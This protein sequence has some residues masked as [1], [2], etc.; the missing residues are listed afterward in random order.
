MPAQLIS[1]MSDFLIRNANPSIVF[2]IKHD[3][4]GRI[5]DGER[6]ELQDRIMS[7]KLIQSI[8]VCQKPNGWI[9]NGF[10]GSNKNAGLYENQEVGVKYLGEKLAYRDAP[11]LKN[12]IAAF[13]TCESEYMDGFLGDSDKFAASGADIIRA[14]CV[15]RAGY[16]DLFDISKEIKRSLESFRRVIEVGSVT[17]IV[18][19]RKKRPERVNPDGIVYVFNDYERWP[20]WYHLDILAHTK[21][22]RS[23]ENVAML[24]ASF[25]KLFETDAPD[26]VPSYCVDV[27]HLLGCCGAF[28]EGMELSMETDGGH[29]VYLNLVEY[30]CRCGLYSRVQKLRREVDIICDSVD[31]QGVCRAGY[32]EAA[33]KGMGTYSGG[34]LE[35]DWK[36]RT[37]RLCDVTYR[38]ALILYCSVD[39]HN[40]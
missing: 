26:Y 32:V 18:K 20:C 24:A 15:A 19:I 29:Q 30:M 13:K 12:A 9:G 27:G 25:N 3:I 7:E 36:S 31:G 8:I 37:R 10:H 4:Q 17:E 38:A 14:A 23:E 21:S 11:V 33:L 2:H 6:R 5:A 22:W 1:R 39:P 16:E 28:K 34:Q 35:T 40:Y